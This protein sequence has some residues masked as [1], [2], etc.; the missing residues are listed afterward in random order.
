M[1]MYGSLYQDVVIGMSCEAYGINA[2]L[3]GKEK[4][5]TENFRGK[6]S[7]IFYFSS[8]TMSNRK[9]I[10]LLIQS[11]NEKSVLNL[12]MIFPN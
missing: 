10:T 2:L 11:N 1:S 7:Y 8:Y 12:Y 4:K 3:Q 6:K 5:K 9:Y